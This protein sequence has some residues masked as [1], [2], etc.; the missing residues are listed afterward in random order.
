MT[1]SAGDMVAG[2]FRVEALAGSGG[3]GSV[4]RARDEQTGQDVALKVLS[5]Q[6]DADLHRFMREASLLRELKHPAIV[7]YVAH[8]ALPD[9]GPFLAM[10]WVHGR[11]LADVL[12]DGP[13]DVRRSLH[14]GL[15]VAGALAC[16][17]R[18]QVIHRDIKPRNV[19]LGV[20][21]AVKV[22]DF[23]I[24]RAQREAHSLT[25]TGV[26]IG[27]PGYIAPEQARGEA[28]IDGRAD[29]F[30]L[31]CVLFEC[32]T[33]RAA[34]VAWD[35]MALL[36]KLVVEE[37]PPPSELAADVP[38]PVDRLVQRMLIKDP[39]A[40][41]GDAAELAREIEALL[42]ALPPAGAATWSG[43]GPRRMTEGELKLLSV[44]LASGQ[45][46]E[47]TTVVSAAGSAV[48]AAA[49]LAQALA[50]LG[51]RAQRLADGSVV[52][53]ITGSEV[54]TD[55]A[56]KAARCALVV[57]QCLRELIGGDGETHDRVERP[58]V[59]GTGR[60]ILAGPLPAGEVIERSVAM[61]RRL[62]ATQH[63]QQAA[64]RGWIG[65]D[66]LT[67]GLLD[68]AFDVR[69]AGQD[70]FL[71][72]ERELLDVRKKLLGREAPFLGRDRELAFIESLFAEC[73]EGPAAAAV[74]V[75]GQAGMGK[76]RL[77][78]ELLAR[79][80]GERQA[81]VLVA[82][83]DALAAQSPLSLVAQLVRRAADIHD[84]EPVEARQLKLRA[85]VLRHMDEAQADR[86][87][88]F[89]GELA[90]ARFSTEGRPALIAARHDPMLMREEIERA[91]CDFLEAELG[92][93][94]LVIVLEDLQWGDLPSVKYVELAL[95]VHRELP[96]FVLIAA[97]NGAEAQFASF[98]ESAGVHE[99]KL[100]KL[101]RA[102][103]KAMI[104]RVLGSVVPDGRLEAIAARA[105][106]N[107]FFLEELIRAVAETES[108]TLPE[109]LI[110]MVNE[111]LDALD[112]VA[113]RILRAASVFGETF[114]SAGLERLLGHSAT[115][116]AVG[117]WLEVL[118]R[119]EI[120]VPQRRSRFQGQQE[121]AFRHALL[122]EAAYA[123]LI[124][125]DKTVA[126]RAAGLWLEEVG[127]SEAGL[128]AEHFERGAEPG[129]AIMRYRMAAEAAL[130]GNDLEGAMAF[131]TRGVTCGASGKELARLRIVQGE[132][133]AVRGDNTAAERHGSEVLT[134]VPRGSAPWCWAAGTTA[135]LR[136]QLGE[137]EGADE[138]ARE[139]AATTPSDAGAA[140][141][142][143]RTC[144]QAIPYLL[145]AGL[146]ETARRLLG[147]AEAA[148]Q[149]D[150]GATTALGWAQLAAAEVAAW[151]EGDAYRSLLAARAAMRSFRTARSDLATAAAGITVAK[152]L[153]E[154]G[155]LEPAAAE[156]QDSIAIADRL[157]ASFY[158]ALARTFA[159]VV[160]ATRGEAMAGRALLETAVESF[161][162]Q[163][164]T[165][166][167]GIARMMLAE[168]LAGLGDLE[169]A[170]RE[171]AEAEL[172]AFFG[173][174]ALRVV[175][176]GVL[177]RVHL[178]RGQPDA[179]LA[180]FE[181]GAAILGELGAV[182]T[183][184]ARFLLGYADALAASG[185]QAEAEAVRRSAA[186]R[187]R[188]R[189]ERIDD[190]D[191]RAA[192]VGRVP[193]HARLLA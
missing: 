115:G 112:P 92:E 116:A 46:D 29:V 135:A 191:V 163:G 74:A 148:G 118:A 132:V 80:E 134:L 171:A 102:A 125:Q 137:V 10:E 51:I 90:S 77:L 38:E 99:L 2:R 147:A 79:I 9:G 12:E 151:T 94:P 164:N 59:I 62:E 95:R 48:S 4:F 127:E 7:G 107:P 50:P 19:M 68:A 13:L 105:D 177:G 180:A 182:S 41:P 71:V 28:D 190:P 128:L 16:A 42:A 181:A 175:C 161:Y 18:R 85:R 130:E 123:S 186:E 129:R 40:R 113:R 21:G 93:R 3:M 26:F 166:C 136:V 61:L 6:R 69:G 145:Y 76:S 178:L 64:A 53:V 63:A 84:D 143:V 104:K 172:V 121:W 25:R 154:L 150:A 75:L 39:T 183:G 57:R 120:V 52:C 140:V 156:L 100:A 119:E 179:A 141:V 110:A 146:Y 8:G 33:G 15:S 157:G 37:V 142:Y 78:W 23:G 88:I 192:Y 34:F 185:R 24:A 35:V 188:A 14:V 43:L 149:A 1:L 82:K 66:Q 31:G 159:G 162:R 176:D 58:V 45:I 32:L 47:G 193:E 103:S 167:F 165:T 27:T 81:T 67:A 131:A 133:H 20:D 173:A 17:H 49:S 60:A 144:A 117:H 139:L 55:L 124:P 56:A 160:A 98:W 138:I 187:L 126:H 73:R 70:L 152:A 122:R 168:V 83:G 97:R 174:P 114:W 153:F 169:G 111:R 170:E 106:G 5:R 184:E 22:L 11:T 86:V 189:V 36:A 65:V 155:L 44:V 89:L 101:S 109:T 87:A 91:W 72:G 108:E 54:A 96:L 30:S 158:G